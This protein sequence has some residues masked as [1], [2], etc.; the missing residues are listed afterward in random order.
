MT[1]LDDRQVEER[2]L[3]ALSRLIFRDKC[4]L[5]NDHN[6]RSITF[7][8]G[9]YLQ[10]EFRA[11]SVDC[12][13]NRIGTDKKFLDELQHRLHPCCQN[14]R[15]GRKT[16]KNFRI[17]PDVIVHTRGRAGP[18]LLAIELKK[19]NN[20]SGCHKCD[21]EKL[22]AYLVHP[23]LKYGHAAFVELVT[24]SPTPRVKSVTWLCHQA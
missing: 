20:R 1:E 16:P 17:F 2:L 23:A 4:L 15:L 22:K 21:I 12:E 10:K 13:Y 9:L 7:R 19:T 6:E 3:E 24:K 5:I 18:N 8:L 14:Y 11:F